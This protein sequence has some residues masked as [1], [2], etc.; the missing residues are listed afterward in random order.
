MKKIFLIFFLSVPI[1]LLL[2]ITLRSPQK[3]TKPTDEIVNKIESQNP[4]ELIDSIA[5]DMEEGDFDTAL[6]K[7]QEELR[8]PDIPTS[9]GMPLVVLAAEKNNYDSLAYLVDMGC[10]VD[11]VDIG[12]G[13]TALIK[14]A[15]NGNIGIIEKLLS[16]N[17][18]VNV[19]T[20]SGKTPLTEAAN[21][22]YGNLTSYLLNRGAVAGVSSENLL[23]YAF[24][25]NYVG[26]DAMLRGGANSNYADNNGNTPL[27]VVSSRGNLS[28]IKNLLAYRANVNAA[29][30]YGMTPL[31]YAIK[32]D[33]NE[34]IRYLL[35][36]P[37]TDIDKANKNNQTPLF[38]AAYNGNTAVVQD[39]LE[40]GADYNKADIK[41]I[42][43]LT[44]AQKKGHTQT[45][46]AISDF[47]AYKNLPKDKQNRVI[48]K[49]R[50][51]MTVPSNTTLA[52]QNANTRTAQYQEDLIK[53]AQAEQEKAI[54]Q[55]KAMTEQ[56]QKQEQM[57]KALE[58]GETP[59]TKKAEQKAN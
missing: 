26:V 55:A 50:Q 23:A 10:N 6:S 27:I 47:I 43:P 20:L 51:D 46:R 57:Q 38:Y 18:N 31:L 14:A 5:R 36:R 37:D 4:K 29:N 8:Y 7:M 34:A 41:G 12:T 39:L 2:W 19:Q 13:E 40:L 54:A 9:K 56:A 44:V 53:K 49:T 33:H 42:T 45:V 59:N 17:A 15:R 32:G 16:A 58:F 24:D 30:K 11:A 28:A 48:M 1:A 52:V 35:S 3:P 25:K 21:K 22:Q